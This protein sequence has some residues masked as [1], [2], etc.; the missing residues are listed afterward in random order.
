MSRLRRMMWTLSKDG[1]PKGRALADRHYSRQSVGATLFVHPGRKLVLVK[2]KGD[3]ADALWVTTWPF[4]EYVRHDWAGPHPTEHTRIVTRK[5]EMVSETPGTWNNALFRN[6]SGVLSSDLIRQAVACTRGVWGDP[7]PMG[8]VTMIWSNKVRP[9]EH[10]GRSYIEA[11]FRH[12]GKTRAGD[13]DV[14]LMSPTDMPEAR[15][16]RDARPTLFRQQ[17]SL[18]R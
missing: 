5:G 9:K 17:T 3:G 13:K 6:E 2:L 14:F 15:M 1:D 11:G 18:S 4:A 7:P 8:M 16:P 10:I 12:V